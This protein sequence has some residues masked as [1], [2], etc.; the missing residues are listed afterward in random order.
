MGRTP[1]SKACWNGQIDIVNRLLKIP[2]LNLNSYD[3]NERSPLHNAVWGENG[4]RIGKKGLSNKDSPECTQ[5]L[6][7]AGANIECLDKEKYSPLMLAASTK[8]IESMKI[9][10]LFGANINHTNVYEATPIIEA[11]RY[12]NTDSV[13]ALIEYGKS[14]LVLK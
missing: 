3:G 4:G 2:N 9:L 8:V 6:I 5:A 13:L 14:N 12:G 11:A 1:L 10:L 7:D